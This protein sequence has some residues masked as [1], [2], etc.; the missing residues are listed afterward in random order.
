MNFELGTCSS[1]I[2]F[3]TVQHLAR[4]GAKVYIAGRSEVRVKAAIE[5]LRAEGLEPGN[6]AIEWLQLDLGDPRKVKESAEKF[7]EK[8]TRLDVLGADCESSV[9]E[10]LCADI[11]WKFIMPACKQETI[12]LRVEALN[13]RCPAL[14]ASM[15]STK[16]VGHFTTLFT[17]TC[18]VCYGE[19]LTIM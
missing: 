3:A 17:N 11:R 10:L 4:K 14:T 5:R 7:A 12:L 6:G 13:K 2:G 16:T 19:M 9:T 15:C 8:E 18:V 1:G